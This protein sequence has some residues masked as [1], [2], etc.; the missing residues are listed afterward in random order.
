[1]RQNRIISNVDKKKMYVVK[2]E[3]ENMSCVNP[4]TK[5]VVNIHET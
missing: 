2:K 4:F 1:M 5:N 3:K